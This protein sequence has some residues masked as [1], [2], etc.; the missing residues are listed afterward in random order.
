MDNMLSIANQALTIDCHIDIILSN[1]CTDEMAGTEETAALTELIFET[2][3][4][5]GCLVAAGDRLTAD[6]SLTSARWQILRAMGDQPR[7][8]AQ[9]ARLMGQSRQAV[10]RIADVLVEEGFA[11][12]SVN[13]DHK[14]AKLIG[15]SDRGHEML[16]EIDRRHAQ[17]VKRLAASFGT[18]RI[19]SALWLLQSLR[20]R[21]VAAERW[22]R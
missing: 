1:G 20:R 10:Q 2:Y 17:W 3:R 13:P 21:L 12:F 8:V 16:E 9:I 19:D 15:L 6:L 7:S 4:L 18:G 14:R 11:A 5:N 22:R